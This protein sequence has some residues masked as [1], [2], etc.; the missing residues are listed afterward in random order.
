MAHDPVQWWLAQLCAKV[1]T[2][3]EIA[4][5]ILTVA[6][7]AE[8]GIARNLPKPLVEQSIAGL[9]RK[10]ADQGHELYRVV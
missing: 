6:A 7:S 3:K 4:Q 1:Q 10:L 5:A 8:R 2:E 9:R